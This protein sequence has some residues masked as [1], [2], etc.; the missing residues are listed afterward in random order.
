MSMRDK[1]KKKASRH[2]QATKQR[3]EVRAEQGL[4][5]HKCFDNAVQYCTEH[6]GTVVEVIAIKDEWPVLHYI[7]KVD[8][9]YLET[10][11]GYKAEYHEYYFLREIL[12]DDHKH[13]GWMFDSALHYLSAPYLKWYHRQCWGIRRIF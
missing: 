9:V 2:I 10:T 13:I 6:G 12:P 4:F 3:I 1:L 11:L 5:Q 7:N 8:G